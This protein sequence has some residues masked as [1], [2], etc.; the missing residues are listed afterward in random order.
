LPINI[1]LANKSEFLWLCDFLLER[2][3]RVAGCQFLKWKTKKRGLMSRKSDIF[4]KLNQII[5][6]F[7]ENVKNANFNWIRKHFF[8]ES[9]RVLFCKTKTKLT[10]KKLQLIFWMMRLPK[11]FNLVKLGY[12]SSS[13]LAEFVH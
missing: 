5:S 13:W 8:V 9:L 6:C 3:K 2:F 11:I 7:F 1:F 10:L 12:T 4:C